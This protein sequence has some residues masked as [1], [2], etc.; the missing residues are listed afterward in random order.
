MKLPAQ[1]RIIIHLFSLSNHLYQIPIGNII[2]ATSLKRQAASR[3][4]GETRAKYLMPAGHGLCET[5][6][7]S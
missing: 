6:W 2:W 1:V 4:T 5:L 7:A 3:N